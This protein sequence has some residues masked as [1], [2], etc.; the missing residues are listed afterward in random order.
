[1]GHG[2]AAA[3]PQ[4]SGDLAA[5]QV[6]QVGMEQAAVVGKQVQVQE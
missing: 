1:M 6:Q 3:V 4:G 5:G 2:L